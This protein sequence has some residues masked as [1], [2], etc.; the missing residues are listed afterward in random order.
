M[1]TRIAAPPT[2]GAARTAAPVLTARPT[3]PPASVAA[4]RSR[5]LQTW[6]LAALGLV[7]GGLL[8]SQLGA[9]DLVGTLADARPGWLAI[10]V[11][12][13][14]VPF[15][16]A[17][18][19]LAAFALGRLPPRRTVAV[20]VASSYAGLVLPPTVGQLAVNAQFLHRLGHG[21]AAVT[22]SVGLTQLASLVVTLVLLGTALAATSTSIVLTGSVLTTV[23]LV[24]MVL[25][26]VGLVLALLP[27]LR[28]AV[29]ATVTGSL[30]EV[31]PRLHAV[32]AEPARLAAGIGG[33]LLVSA[34]YVIALDAS[35]RAVGTTLPL[36]QTAI[37]VLAGTALGSAAPT[38]GGIVA[39]EAALAGGLIAAGVPASAA[40]PAV[41][42]YRAVTLWLRVAP[43]WVALTLLRRRG[44]L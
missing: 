23:V 25:L 16:G 24:G 28:R 36:A 19:S 12:A 41:L 29:A 5:T 38:P 34:G 32:V 42:L 26:G 22:A 35:L 4:G 6:V 30:H 43:G 33:S 8:V 13:S 39:V 1:T 17:A 31:W 2:A 27:R 40:L 18:L 9:V 20:Q 15:V 37:V 21:S 10:A 11:G 14:L 3:A 44:V 7:S